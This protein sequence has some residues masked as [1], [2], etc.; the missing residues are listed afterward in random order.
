MEVKM[1]E[2]LSARK[3]SC[4]IIHSYLDG[5]KQESELTGNLVK[6]VASKLITIQAEIHLVSIN[7]H[8]RTMGLVGE[9]LGHEVI[10]SRDRVRLSPRGKKMEVSPEYVGKNESIKDQTNIQDCSG[11]EVQYLTTRRS[12]AGFL[13]CAGSRVGRLRITA[14]NR[15][16]KEKKRTQE[17]SGKKCEKPEPTQNRI[18]SDSKME[19]L[20]RPLLKSFQCVADALIYQLD[21]MDHQVVTEC[22][23]SIHYSNR[24]K[25]RGLK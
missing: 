15:R 12:P 2:Q 23:G 17:V 22:H 7:L 5:G 21:K 4:D 19:D 1:E 18:N 24:L 10:Q 6:Q 3:T 9:D 25:N 8:K 14:L 16:A 13:A 20:H 11:K